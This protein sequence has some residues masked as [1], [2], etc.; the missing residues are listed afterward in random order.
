M[1]GLR[2]CLRPSFRAVRPPSAAVAA[3]YLRLYSVAAA[4]VEA[5]VESNE[6]SREKKLSTMQKRNTS[7]LALK[8]DLYPR[9]E[10]NYDA[11]GIE[12]KSCEAFL[13]LA[14]TVPAGQT[15]NNQE[16]RVYGTKAR[17]LRALQ[18]FG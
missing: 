8:Q 15:L 18:S 16:F 17:Q 11:Q 1:I 4:A 13:E 14:H 2:Q 10:S 12:K 5:E 6:Q 9:C 3:S 7:L